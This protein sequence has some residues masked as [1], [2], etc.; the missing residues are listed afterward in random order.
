[1]KKIDLNRD[2]IINAIREC[3]DSED[4]ELLNEFSVHDQEEMMLNFCP[5]D[6]MERITQKTWDI[7]DEFDNDGIE[8]AICLLDGLIN[9]KRIEKE[10]EYDCD[11]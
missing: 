2:D 8:E 3:I 6:C 1:M 10:I 9:N 11:N 4:C 5:N 7:W